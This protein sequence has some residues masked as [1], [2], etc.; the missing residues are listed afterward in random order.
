[1]ELLLVVCVFYNANLE[2]DPGESQND[3][4][5]ITDQ[6]TKIEHPNKRHD[7]LLTQNP[8][9]YIRHLI[10]TQRDGC[11]RTWVGGGEWAGGGKV[12]GTN[13][14]WRLDI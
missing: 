7:F 14:G 8:P 2:L 13:E 9:S 5:S 12:G 4:G 1:M 6:P 10:P 11:A 3:P